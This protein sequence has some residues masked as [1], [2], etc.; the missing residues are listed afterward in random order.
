MTVLIV[1]RD[2]GFAF[3]L[4]RA[5]DELGYGS[6]PARD[7]PAAVSLI[8][9]LNLVVDLLLV[10]PQLPGIASL[11]QIVKGGESKARVISV[12]DQD[13]LT[14]AFPF[15]GYLPRPKPFS[16]S[17]NLECLALIEGLMVRAA[18]VI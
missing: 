17:Q 7:I 12:G 3:W 13:T 16:Q 15:D 2:L 14:P 1:E 18:V 6:Y 9:Q 8:R 10:D 11:A 4:G 5:L